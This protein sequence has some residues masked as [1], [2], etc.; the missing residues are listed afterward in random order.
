MPIKLATQRQRADSQTQGKIFI[1]HDDENRNIAKFYLKN[2]R[3]QT[4]F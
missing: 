2:A 1:S 4:I 3:L